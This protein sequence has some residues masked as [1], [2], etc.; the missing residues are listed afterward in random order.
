LAKEGTKFTQ[1]YAGSTVS[2]SSPCALMTGK[3]MG[4]AHIRQQ[5]IF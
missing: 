3:H 4:H 1:F 2:A 5:G